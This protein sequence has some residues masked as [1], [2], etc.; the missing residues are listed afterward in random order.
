MRR[1]SSGRSIAKVC[2]CAIAP[3]LIVSVRFC[4]PSAAWIREQGSRR[5]RCSQQCVQRLAQARIIYGCRLLEGV[6]LEISNGDQERANMLFNNRKPEESATDDVVPVR[7][8]RQ[9][10]SAL[11]ATSQSLS[12]L[13]TTGGQAGRCI[14]DKSLVITGNL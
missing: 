1:P 7:E 4:M 12:S 11:A 13:R 2:E 6:R 10:A 8:S 9:P 14:I 5:Q 3:N